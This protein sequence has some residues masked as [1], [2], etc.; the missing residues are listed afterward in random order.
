MK[1]TYDQTFQ[2]PLA[3]F[4]SELVRMIKDCNYTSVVDHFGYALAYDRPLAEAIDSDIKSC[5]NA[6]GRSAVIANSKEPR[7]SI[8]Y[9]EQPNDLSLFGLVECFLSLEQDDGELLVEL[10]VSTDKTEFHLW[11]EDVS[12]IAKQQFPA[13]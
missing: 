13:D 7:I 12:H 1:I 2:K 11:L 6:E 3:N 9:F 5:L 8:K 4:G 10:I